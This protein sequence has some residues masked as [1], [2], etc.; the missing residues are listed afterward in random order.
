MTGG[1]GQVPPQLQDYVMQRMVDLLAKELLSGKPLERPGQSGVL[2]P[3]QL[4]A[5]IPIP[6]ETV[7][8][9]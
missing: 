4:P 1:P 6:S 9:F 5:L 3:Q 2:T 7:N 8:P